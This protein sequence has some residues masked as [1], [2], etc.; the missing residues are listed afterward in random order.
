M[1]AV[2][3]QILVK[4]KTLVEGLAQVQAL[5]SAVK[6]LN[7]SGGRGLGDA[8]RDVT[9]LGT[10][11]KITTQNTAAL[12]TGFRNL[13]TEINR[14][15]IN[16]YINDLSRAA[17][18]TKALIEPTR[19]LTA[20]V[21]P[22][23][24]SSQARPSG[25]ARGLR[26]LDPFQ[27]PNNQGTIADTVRQ[28]NRFEGAQEAVLRSAENYGRKASVVLDQVGVSAERSGSKLNTL[29]AKIR[30]VTS[31]RP[32]PA[33]KVLPGLSG[34]DN[35][36]QNIAAAIKTSAGARFLSSPGIGTAAGAAKFTAD[37]KKLEGQ[38]TK[39]GK[40]VLG[41]R[42]ASG[43]ALDGFLTMILGA[44]RASV[45]LG[46]LAGAAG[47]LA[48]ILVTIGTGAAAVGFTLLAKQ[49]VAYNS[50]LEAAKVSLASLIA[51]T[52]E[53]KNA[54]GEI[55]TGMEAFNAA[56]AIA[57]DQMSKI[58]AAAIATRYEFQDILQAVTLGTAAVGGTNVTLEQTVALVSDL[59]RAA[60][61][62]KL[63]PETFQTQVRQILT[64][65]TRVQT[66]LATALFPGQNATEINKQIKQFRE[67]GTLVE[68]LTKRLVVFR[69]TAN[70]VENTFESLSSN[71]LDAFKLF[72]GQATFGLFENLKGTLQ[73]IIGAIIIF[74]EKGV[75][76]TPTFQKVADILND[77]YNLVGQLIRGAIAEVSD[78]L[79][80]WADYIYANKEQFEDMLISVVSIA[81]SIGGILIDL[82]SI[83]GDLG[84][85]NNNTSNWATGMQGVALFFGFIRDL[86]NVIIGSLQVVIGLVGQGLAAT[87]RVTL[88]LFN[89]IYDAILGIIGLYDTAAAARQRAVRDSLTT[90]LLQQVEDASGNFATSGAVRAGRGLDGEGTLGA[91]DRLNQQFQLARQN[92][93]ASGFSALPR[94]VAGEGGAGDA[95]A[96][97]R[98]AKERLRAAQQLFDAISKYQIQNAK[99]EAELFK[100]ANEQVLQSYERRYEQ[101]LIAAEEF[102]NKK[103][104]LELDS[105]ERE[106][107]AL[108]KAKTFERLA[109]GRDLGALQ[110]TFQ[111]TEDELIALEAKL[112][113]L[114]PDQLA[115]ADPVTIK[116][117]TEYIKYLEQT[118]DIT[119]DL[120][121]LEIKRGEIAKKTAQ[122]IKDQSRAY[123]QQFL[124]IRGELATTL[125]QD[126]VAQ[127]NDLRKRI[128]DQLPGVLTESNK[129]VP[130]I[131]QVATAIR[132]LGAVDINGVREQFAA[133]N[134]DI[135]T[136]SDETQTLLRLFAALETVVK[137]NAIQSAANRIR[138]TAEFDAEG[139]A[140]AFGDGALNLDDALAA[141]AGI[142]SQVV[143]D[144]TEKYNELKASIDAV[145]EGGGIVDPTQVQAA[146]ALSRAIEAIK[147]DFGALALIQAQ[148][149]RDAASFGARLDAITIK[150][151]SGAIGSKAAREQI[152]QVQLEQIAALEAEL[153]R[154]EALDQK[155]PAV[156]AKIAA[157]RN[158]IDSLRND[159]NSDF[160]STAQTINGTIGDAF[161][162]FLN[163]IQDGTQSIAESFRQL[164]AS[165]LLGIAKAIAQALLLKFI[166]AP[167]G[168]TGGDSGGAGGFLSGLIFGKGKASGGFIS[169]RGTSVSDSILTPLSNGEAVIPAS[170]VKRYG[171]NMISAIIN[172]SFLPTSRFGYA[173]GGFS[174]E[175]P[176]AAGGRGGVR[177]I[178]TVDPNLVREFMSSSAGEEIILN[179]IGNNPG[180]LQRLA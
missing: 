137:L 93:R 35:F 172:G 83:V 131:E 71:V 120:A 180:L 124:D 145:E 30:A 39:T 77:V 11:S 84:A 55:V 152:K 78:I 170:A 53:I 16:S 6:G 99:R 3:Q 173:V 169:G 57:D 95:R 133:F 60:G 50:E 176:G 118:A 114:D 104:E 153:A 2:E 135:D 37:L 7:R 144:L 138:S 151:Q 158:E 157:V 24:L 19:L 97:Q 22:R 174:G 154:L 21:Q 106:K 17:R 27:Q 8:T 85:A 31:G 33:S 168:L 178:N 40:S 155:L 76:L 10:A 132:D 117:A 105:L 72:V 171:R 75:R 79:T 41:L 139:V 51:S 4:I 52:S 116:Q 123:K 59:A 64:G 164:V 70:T 102:F 61:A 48:A 68:E 67:S 45:I 62:L 107:A 134:I 54:N 147:N 73:D 141:N 129:G 20:G 108:E 112:S 167:L 12:F 38:A 130:G 109:L 5:A 34:Q 128:S 47:A 177:I 89:G 65:A 56:T 140:T 82:A 81:E 69:L 98:E 23:V 91:L 58:Q 115:N 46:S 26:D 166:L 110:G 150:Q 122:D 94:R 74:D 136:L 161:S 100:L 146:G 96:A 28:L 111:L 80:E 18:Q 113:A 119:Q 127:S 88:G 15:G 121:K 165:L 163:N 142:Q 13:S 149:D 86:I 44:G 162:T 42:G 160:I 25:I 43:Q 14:T 36:E 92:R 49:G 9:K 1:A 175:R 159:V 143:A 126:G 101:G 29:L 179:V 156:V 148:A 87:L 103:N 90:G 63:S 32:T 66:Q 125:G